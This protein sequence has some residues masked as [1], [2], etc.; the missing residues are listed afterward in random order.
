VP[1]RRDVHRAFDDGELDL[2][3]YL[4]AHGCFAELAHAVAEHQVDPIALL[5]RCTGERW[6]PERTAA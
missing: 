5:Q 1:L 6:T 3:P 2:L 4:I